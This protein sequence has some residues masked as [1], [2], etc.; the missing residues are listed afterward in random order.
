MDPCREKKISELQKADIFVFPTFNEAFPLVLLEASQFSLPVISTFEGGIPDI[1]VDGKT[2][3]LVKSQNPEM[4]AEKISILLNNSNLR[5]EMGRNAYERFI[6]NF[7]IDIFEKNMLKT[8]NSI[9]NAKT[10]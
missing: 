8:F 6:N 4:L 3:F 9:L 10:L 2:G 5:I 7:T 1:V